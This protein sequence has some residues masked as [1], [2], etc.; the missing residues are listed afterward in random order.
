VRTLAAWLVALARRNCRWLSVAA[1]LGALAFAIVCG[2][3][4]RDFGDHW[5]ESYH[6]DGVRLAVANLHFFHQ[7]YIYGSVY[8][9]LGVAVVFFH[10]PTFFPSFVREMRTMNTYD[11]AREVGQYQSVQAFQASAKT[12]IDSPDYVLQTRMLFFVTSSLA[13]I[14]VYL[15]LRKLYPGRYLGALAAAAFLIF[16]WEL[17][18]HQR[19]I[20]IDAVLAQ[21]IAAALLLLTR[22][23][24]AASPRSF[25]FNYLGAAAVAGI[26]FSCKAPGLV[27]IVPVGLLP[28]LRPGPSPVPALRARDCLGLAALVFAATAVVLQPGLAIDLPRMLATWASQAVNYENSAHV[29]MTFGV[30]ERVGSFLAWLWLAVPSPYLGGSVL[31]SL[32]VVV[33]LARFVQSHRRLACLAGAV[34]VVLLTMMARH[35]LLIVR[36]YLM[37]IP[38]MALA[39]GVGV[40][41]LQARLARRRPW[42]W[43]L[44]LGAVAVVFLLNGRWLYAS[45]MSIRQTTSDS[46]LRDVAADLLRKPQTVRVSAGLFADLV[47]RLSTGFR[48][49]DAETPAAAAHGAG[50][51]LVIRVSERAWRANAYGLSRRFYGARPANYDWYPSWIARPAS[52][53]LVLAPIQVRWYLPPN[54]TF[55][56]C[57]PLR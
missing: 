44:A 55:A 32:I 9:L 36:Q 12:L 31:L 18:Y 22:A 5:D 50:S 23:W 13:A 48:C 16:S 41:A 45:A 7:R 15:T 33:G 57:E 4:G 37:L 35:P 46:I 17:H 52:P 43:R 25:L 42:L 29:N 27:A 2:W 26:A 10:H 39:F 49:H 53:V 28:F 20:A 30:G 24:L 6:V 51:P 8:L 47:P 1:V 34:A 40:M 14:W 19:F 3:L 38:L 11:S 54:E 21:V 56:L